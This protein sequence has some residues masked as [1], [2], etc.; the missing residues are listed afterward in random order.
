MEHR[1]QYPYPLSGWQY[2]GDSDIHLNG[3]PNIF[4]ISDVNECIHDIYE[5]I[6]W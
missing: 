6:Y 5:N 1:W 3:F 4:L 2:K